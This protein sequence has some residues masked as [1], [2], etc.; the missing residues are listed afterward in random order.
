MFFNF[1]C[2]QLLLILVFASLSVTVDA[3]GVCPICG[4]RNCPF[5]TGGSTSAMPATPAAKEIGNLYN[6]TLQKLLK[7]EQERRQRLHL[8]APQQ[9]EAVQIAQKLQE[10]AKAQ[11]A[12]DP[13]YD[14]LRAQELT[15]KAAQVSDPT[16]RSQTPLPPSEFQRKVEN[17]I[18]KNPRTKDYPPK[19]RQLFGDREAYGQL[20]F[21]VEVSKSMSSPEASA[22]QI[23]AIPFENNP[24]DSRRSEKLYSAVQAYA[25][26]LRTA[27]AKDAESRGRFENVKQSVSSPTERA[28]VM[29][30]ESS[31]PETQNVLA[32]QT[33]IA[34]ALNMEARERTRGLRITEPPPP[35]ST[36]DKD[37]ESS[38]RK[39]GDDLAKRIGEN[40]DRVHRIY[41]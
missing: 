8:P 10:E 40:I 35:A 20:L 25:D 22:K 11:L 15:E 5:A 19:Q 37:A 13:K 2:H 7:A 36:G 41:H 3:Q 33:A 32:K 6:D 27:G 30:S 18:E 39:W 28:E 12:K 34:T 4:K 9:D 26:N 38:V 29:K 24:G 31:Q 23:A 17:V 16:I 14:R 21:A 1:S